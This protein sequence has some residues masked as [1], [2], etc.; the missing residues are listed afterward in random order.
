[1]RYIFYYLVFINLLAFALM[2]QDKRRAIRN[3]WRIPE[4]TLFLCAL[5]GGSLGSILGIQCFRHKTKHRSF[6]IGM[7]LILALQLVLC[8]ALWWKFGG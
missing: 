7:P 6:T 2:G 5:L 4:R 1:M 8:A 3:V